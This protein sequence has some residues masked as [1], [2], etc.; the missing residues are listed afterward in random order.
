M[1]K[2]YLKLS[3]IYSMTLSLVLLKK[4]DEIHDNKH[5]INTDDS[6]SLSKIKYLSN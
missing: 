5:S 2:S 4:V 1:F 6:K 3:F